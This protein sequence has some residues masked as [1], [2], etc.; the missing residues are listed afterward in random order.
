MSSY[1]SMNGDTCLADSAT[2]HTILTDRKY[3]SYLVS[4]E[5]DVNT[6]SDTTKI[7]KGSGSANISL[8]GGTQLH[9]ENAL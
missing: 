4:R 6:I 8:Y 7:I 1:N 9:I 3:F 5:A 2:T